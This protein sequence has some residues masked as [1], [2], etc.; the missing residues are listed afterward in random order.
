MWSF[1]RCSH[2]KKFRYSDLIILKAFPR[3]SDDNRR[4]LE[5]KYLD[6]LSAEQASVAVHKD[7]PLMAIAGPGSGKSESMVRRAAILIDFHGI[8][9]E[10][11]VLTTFTEK[12]ADSLQSKVKKQLQTPEIIEKLTVGLFIVFVWIYSKILVLNTG[13]LIDLL[14]Y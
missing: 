2:M 7:G 1:C 13:S 4:R 11:I 3:I 6:F 9:P 8:K 5:D 10:N 14:E 12:A